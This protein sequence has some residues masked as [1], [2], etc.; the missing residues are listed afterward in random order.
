M[1]VNVSNHPSSLWLKNQRKNAMEYG[2]IVDVAFPAIY[3]EY[4][5]SKYDELVEE[6]LEKILI[7][8]PEAVMVQGEFIFTYRLVKELKERSIKVLS[9]RSERVSKEFKD[10]NDVIHKHSIF[11]FVGFQEYYMVMF[12]L[13]ILV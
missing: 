11:E 4:N 12:I 13:C 9:S 6:Y 8:Q 3:K 1:F 7:L 2:E 5:S 10:E